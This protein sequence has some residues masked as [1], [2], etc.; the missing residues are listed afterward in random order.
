M[1]RYFFISL[2]LIGLG[3]ILYLYFNKKEEYFENKYYELDRQI[4]HRIL[5]EK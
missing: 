1:H 4:L 5:I 3:T 2:F